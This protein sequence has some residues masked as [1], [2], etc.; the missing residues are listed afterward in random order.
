MEPQLGLYVRLGEMLGLGYPTIGIR[1]RLGPVVVWMVFPR[2]DPG[3]RYEKG[4]IV[5]IV[6]GEAH[7]ALGLRGGLL[8]VQ[9]QSHIG[10][11]IISKLT[12]KLG[13]LL[14]LSPIG[15]R[16]EP[17]LGLY[18]R[19]GEML[20][21]GYPT[22]GIR[23]RL[24]PVVV[25]M[26]FPR[27]DPG[28]TV[29]VDP[30][31]TLY[32]KE[33]GKKAGCS[34]GKGRRYEKGGIM[35]IVEGEAHGGLGLRGGLLGVQ[36]QSHIGRII[37]SKLKY[38]LGGLL[39]LSPIGFGM[40]P[41]LGL[42]VRLGEMLG[43]GYPTLRILNSFELTKVL[44]FEA[45]LASGGR[46]Y[47]LASDFFQQPKK[48]AKQ[49]QNLKWWLGMDGCE[50]IMDWWRFLIEDNALW[51]KVVRSFHGSQ[52]GLHYASLIRRKSGPWY[53]IA[54][55]NDDLLND[56]GI[57]L[58]LIF[59]K[60]IGNVESTHFWLD[61]WLGGPTLKET[62]PHIFLLDNQSNC[63]V[64]DRV[65]DNN[66]LRNENTLS[67]NTL[68]YSSNILPI[69]L[70]FNWAWTRTIRSNIEHAE[71]IDI[72]NMLANLFLSPSCDIWECVID[73]TRSFLVK[74]LRTHITN[75]AIALDQNHPRWN[76]LVPIKVNIAS[77]RIAK[78][79]L[80]TKIN[81]DLSGIDLH[82]VNCA[83]CDD[84][85]AMEHHLF[86]HY[87]IAKQVWLDVLRWWNLP[88]LTSQPS[89]NCSPLLI[90]LISHA[91]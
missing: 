79:R 36:T 12:Y 78:E 14:L 89:L 32:R 37:I 10:K 54:K 6:E 53:R 9:T 20:G 39:L 76:K 40:E 17:Q 18:V 25:W 41:Q 62:F 50:Q 5:A 85:L 52:G 51:C 27:L 8:G 69:N 73:D 61:N 26:V 46:E 7:G 48:R 88:M 57:N 56:Y 81:L 67:P 42:Y 4:G 84:D 33:A 29:L 19:L 82:L 55:L 45:L 21:L 72:S 16:M 58:P 70:R 47:E 65:L 49:K 77:W 34:D 59:K 63:L 28:S 11:I 31:K 66:G 2:L 24:G 43:L 91:T 15:F 44:E 13:G 23:A 90:I 3:R 80:L 87:R 35:A 64:C 1:A 83:L 68:V 75:T 22:I 30:G 74:C 86:I 38:K 60:K 71:I